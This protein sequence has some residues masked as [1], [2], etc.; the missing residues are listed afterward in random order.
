[1]KKLPIS[2]KHLFLGIKSVFWFS[3]G[4]VLGLFF[5]ISFAFIFFQKVYGEKIYP[6][7][8]VNSTNLGGKTEKEA[9]KYFDQQNAE[10]ENT[11]FTFSYGDQIA[12]IS[13]KDI[14]AGYNGTLLAHQAYTIGRSR[15]IL[16]DIVLVFKA[17]ISGLLLSPSY[18]Y[19]DTQLI[20]LLTPL[21]QKAT[22]EPKNAQ[23]T[24]ENN[25]VTAFTLSSDGQGVDIELIKKMIMEKI[26][27]LV[28]FHKTQSFTMLIPLKVLKPAI[29]SESV[30]NYGIKELIGTGESLYQHSIPSR[31]FNV[32]L[33]ATRMNGVLIPPGEDFSFDKALGDVSSY[34]GYQQA[35]VIAG[36]HTVL[37]DGG[38]VCQVSTTFFRALLNA[39]LPITERHAHDYRVGYYEEDSPPGLDATVY[40]PSVDLR[41]KND[42]GHW[43]LVQSII[44]P[45]NLRITFNL[46]GTN[47]GRKAVL[48]APVITG[49]TPAP[50]P[51]Y[52]DDPTL[53]VGKIVQTDFAA[54]GA[55]VSF[56][57]T[58]V[59]N[60][61][62]IISDTY[63]SFYRPWQAVFLK[64]TKQ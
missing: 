54:A 30:N 15:F 55:H 14:G 47:D 60:G 21:I 26:P 57:R 56:S 12:T 38:G 64:G 24:F 22:I 52:Q 37:G 23:F 49:E 3:V 29:S 19:N 18:Q 27:A 34:T 44:D 9:I 8:Y 7:I 2:R 40:V 31:V 17:Y 4:I 61:S 13:A 59:R 32:T 41:F 39:G 36:G 28:I 42:T 35:Y 11:D 45:I 16:S 50:P 20:H 58:V 51:L 25:R 48:T 63:D 6:G 1:M 43:I 10:V 33:A 5:T 46:F 53:P 62:V